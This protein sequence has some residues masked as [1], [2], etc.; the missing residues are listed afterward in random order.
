MT[1]MAASN[2]IVQSIVDDDKRGRVMSFYTMAFIGMAPF[3]SLIAGSLASHIGATNALAISG[4]FCFIAATFFA[5]R[6]P[7]LK[8]ILHPVFERH[9]LLSK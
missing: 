5:S 3:G 8:K 7:E 1:T 9:G 4:V 2:T 6:L